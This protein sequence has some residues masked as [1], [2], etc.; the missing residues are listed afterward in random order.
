VKS[1]DYNKISIKPCRCG[2]NRFT[3]MSRT[4]EQCDFCGAVRSQAVRAPA[5][6][7]RRKPD[8]TAKW[9]KRE[10]DV[11]IVYPRRCDGAFL[12]GILCHVT[13]AGWTQS[14]FLKELDARGYDVTT[15]RFSISLKEKKS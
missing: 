14:S 2:E 5:L 9:S 4:S 12:Q 13:D 11:M 1:S 7:G 10:R 3:W 6:M 8:L 15:L